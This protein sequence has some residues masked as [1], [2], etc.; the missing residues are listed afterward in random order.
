MIN[1]AIAFFPH[2]SLLNPK[3]KYTLE[4]SRIIIQQFVL[5][6]KC[7]YFLCAQAPHVFNILIIRNGFPGISEHAAFQD[8]SD[9]FSWIQHDGF[10]EHVAD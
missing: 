4:T 9:R 3:E 2:Q 8:K 10:P 6:G 7:V 5:T 1:D